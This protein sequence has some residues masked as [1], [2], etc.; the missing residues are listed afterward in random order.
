VTWAA[1]IARAFLPTPLSLGGVVVAQLALALVVGL[2]LSRG[3]ASWRRPASWAFVLAQIVAVAQL[4]LGQPAGFRMLAII[5]VALWSLKSVVSVEA[6]IAGESPLAW[7]R[8]LL[9]AAAWPGMRP[10]AF[11]EELAPDR[12]AAADLLVRGAIWS[13]VGAGLM[14]LAHAIQDRIVAATAVGLVA[15]S[16]VLH[17][18]AF[19]L[20]AGMWR[21]VGFG[22]D[23][24]FI[25]PLAAP[26]LANFWGKR[27]NLAFSEMTQIAIYRPCSARW[28]KG[29][30]AGLGFVYSG[31]LH[32]MAISLPVGRG[33]G[34]PLLYFLV[35]GGLVLLERHW[36][37]S[38]TPIAERGPIRHAWT[39]L[40]LALPMPI[41]FHT[42]FL[43]GVVWPLLGIVPP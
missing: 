5:G 24:L 2:V 16:L 9:F 25:A 41:L 42:P 35:H 4:S 26:S 7:W 29:I 36:Y 31:L 8:W 18:G 13:V 39:L 30:G 12:R 22:T 3:G 40:W 32:E 23:R 1:S 20:A 10:S 34:L 37:R 33:F 27:W 17:F 15:I 28:G 14:G 19:N 11:G 21:L 38:G 6:V 43:H